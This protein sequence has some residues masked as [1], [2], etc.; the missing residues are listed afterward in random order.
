[1]ER[2]DSTQL[3]SAGFKHTGS[4]DTVRCEQCR[5]EVS[6]WTLGTKPFDFHREQSPHCPFIQSRTSPRSSDK[7]L[8]I[9]TKN[10]VGNTL[11]ASEHENP[12]KRQKIEGSQ[13]DS[14]LNTL[15]EIDTLAQVRRRG[16]SHWPHRISSDAQMIDAGFFSCNVG[17]RVIC[18]YCNLI[19]QSWT[20]HTDDPCEV[21]KTISPNC[22]YVKA[23]LIRPVA[24]SMPIVNE[25]LA[26]ASA[27]ILSPSVVDLK[28]LRP[29]KIISTTAY[30]PAYAEIPKRHASFVTWPQENL[31]A[32]DDLVRAGFFFTGIK[33]S[34]TCFYCDGSLQNWDPSDNPMI[35]HARWFPCC[36]YAKQLYGDEM[37]RK[38]QEAKRAQQGIFEQI[39]RR[40]GIFFPFLCR[41]YESERSKFWNNEQ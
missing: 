41:P 12:Y 37:Y 7:Q 11:K 27:N 26:S 33:D 3:L 20:P 23:K 38:I 18:I 39:S 21:H 25:P 31:S 9:E 10:D 29:Q 36:A 6:K 13:I 16:F 19:C 8:A 30:N 34:V 32:I 1:M 15:Y 28:L 2:G 14:S 17:D 35:E 22:I 40:S 24:S 4:G 5:L